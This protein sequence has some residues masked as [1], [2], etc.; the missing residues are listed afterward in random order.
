MELTGAQ[1]LNQTTYHRLRDTINRTY[2]Q[3]R[4]VA[5]WNDRVVAD[6]AAVKELRALLQAQGI[7]PLQALAVEAGVDLPDRVTILSPGAVRQ[8]PHPFGSGI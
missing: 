4:F 3:G 5:V 2:P 6:A 7:D 1:A 8:C